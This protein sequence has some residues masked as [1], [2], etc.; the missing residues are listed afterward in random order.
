[1]CVRADH[2]LE[3]LQSTVCQAED[4][5]GSVEPFAADVSER[6]SSLSFTASRMCVANPFSPRGYLMTTNVPFE[7]F[8][9]ALVRIAVAKYCQ[10]GSLVRA[11]DAAE[12]FDML[13]TQ[14]IAHKCDRFDSNGF[15]RDKLLAAWRSV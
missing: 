6:E 7:G 4:L 15:R 5:V 8:C 2:G 11:A 12:A 10:Q 13:L 3:A 9:E 14:H 1:M